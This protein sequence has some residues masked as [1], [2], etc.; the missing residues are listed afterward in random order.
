MTQMMKTLMI[1]ELRA[2]EVVAVG[3]LVG[4]GALVAGEAL[5]V[6]GALVA[7]GI[8]RANSVAKEAVNVIQGIYS[9]GE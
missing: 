2:E 6:G 4:G 1:E 8:E 9:K 5:V 7:R 3:E